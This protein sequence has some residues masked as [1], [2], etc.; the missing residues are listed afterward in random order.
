[1]NDK[2][3]IYN[4]INNNVVK[5]ISKTFN[6]SPLVATI[7][8]NRGIQKYEDIKMFLKNDITHLHDPFLMKDM[9]KAVARIK[10]A[11]ENKE[12]ITVYG[13]YDVDGV[14]STAILVKYLLTCGAYVDYYIPDRI[15]EGYGVNKY[16][17]EK[18]HTNGTTLMITVDSGI[19]ALEEVDYANKLGLDIIVTDHHE[20]KEE[21]PNACAVLNPKQNDCNYPFKELAGVGVTFK[22]LQALAGKEN[23]LALINDYCDIV[24]LGT[25]ADVVPL[26]GENRLIVSRGLKSMPYTNNL[27]LKS[28][29]KVAGLEGKKIS[30]GMVGFSIAPRVNAAGRIGSALRAVELFLTDD[31]DIACKIAQELNEENKNRQETEAYILQEALEF[32]ERDFDLNKQKVIVLSNK[33]WHH[34]VIG[35]VA[36][37]ITEKFYR[38]S[39]LI[40]LEGEEG[41]GS[42]RSISGFNLFK[43]LTECKDYLVSFG[44]HELAAGL[45]I[46]KDKIPLFLRYINEYADIELSD[47]DLIPRIYI[48]CEI[49][50]EHLTFDSIKQLEVLEPFGMGNASPVFAFCNTTISDIRT[51]GDSKHLKLSVEKNGILIDAIGFNMGS[52]EEQFVVGDAVDIACS[53][54]INSYNEQEKIQ[55][56]IKDIKL[57]KNKIIECKYYKT[58]DS[59]VRNDIISNVISSQTIDRM[60]EQKENLIS[61]LNEIKIN[62]NCLIIVNTLRGIREILKDIKVSGENKKSYGIHFNT[63]N[64]KSSLDI[65][66]NPLMHNLDVTGY[67]HIYIYDPCFNLSAIYELFNQISYFNSNNDTNSI[68]VHIL[69][70]HDKF[71]WCKEVM[72]SIIPERHDF[73]IVYQ[74]IKT[75]SINEVY[76]G[77]LCLLNRSISISYNTPM[78]YLKIKNCLQIFEELGLI[79]LTISDDDVIIKQCHHKGKKVNI[80]NS[81]KLKKLRSLRDRLQECENFFLE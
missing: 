65:L 16:A 29:I 69:F 72:D 26:L 34:G 8:A 73:V 25:I 80:E 56:I 60:R 33:N 63:I 70:D 46:N 22:L 27:G 3:W 43:A 36:S 10:R 57:E 14:T 38:P 67:N 48:D 2:K 31:A 40:A 68:K 24:C 1:M 81:L 13:D 11:I 21:I 75:R 19:T 61:F 12:R 47:D 18:I 9:N 71:E 64:K 23:F 39:I 30:T 15:N 6:I 59:C 79:K 20:C 7:I 53:L 52:Y 32:I 44:G 28:L 50:V 74:Y 35:I 51:V 5:K 76:S 62:D 37:R 49:H 66:I 42:G 77:N 58:F 54:G 55:L 17:L 41:K 78:N 4:D 45:S